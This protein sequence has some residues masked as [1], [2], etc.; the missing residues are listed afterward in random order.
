MEQ[1]T[2][3]FL[4]PAQSSVLSSLGVTAITEQSIRA[5]AGSSRF[6][7]TVQDKCPPDLRSNTSTSS[8]SD[9]KSYEVH[10]S[11]VCV[12]DTGCSSLSTTKPMDG[13][14][15]NK[16]MMSE[17]ELLNGGSDDGALSILLKE[18]INNFGKFN[19]DGHHHHHVSI[20]T[21]PSS[22]SP[23]PSYSASVYNNR[24][25]HHNN[26]NQQ[27]ESRSQSSS[28]IISSSPSSSIDSIGD[29]DNSDSDLSSPIFSRSLRFVTPA[30]PSFS[31]SSSS[32]SSDISLSSDAVDTSSYF[33]QNNPHV[34]LTSIF[35]PGCPVLSAPNTVQPFV[36]DIWVGAVVTNAQEETKT[37]YAKARNSDGFDQVNLKESVMELI[38]VAEEQFECTGV[39]LCLEKSS[40]DLKELIHSLMYVGGTVIPPNLSNMAYRSDYVLVGIEI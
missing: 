30:S 29:S 14:W 12:R 19:L 4:P 10:G 23:P 9:N 2:S 5:A 17:K 27:T 22:P 18:Q 34:L 24:H 16:M 36:E 35:S 37:L 1:Q 32:S 6:P 31:S 25:H 38:E 40:S 26:N 20:S 15:S 3:S 21:L 13:G 8:K 39:V 33:D 28:I 7:D 11:S